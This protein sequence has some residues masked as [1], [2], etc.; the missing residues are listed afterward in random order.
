[1]GRKKTTTA[2][3][4]PAE[5][6]CGFCGRSQ[7]EAGMLVEGKLPGHYICNSCTKL[8]L[9]ILEREMSRRTKHSGLLL[10]IP[11]PREITDKLD[12]YVIGQSQAKKVLAVSVHNHYKRLSSLKGE[13][14]TVVE[15]SNVL[16]LGS[17]GSGKT[18]LAKTLAKIINVPF[19]IG[20]ATTLTEAGYVGDD[21]ESLLLKL[22]HSANMDVGLAEMGIIYID[23]IDK[24]A[25]SS[26]NV[27]ITR[28]VSG[29]G[30]QQALLKMIEGTI[31]SVPPQG[32]RKHPEQK[33]IDIDT[34][35]ILFICGGT[36]VGLNKLVSRRIGKNQMGF[37]TERFKE[38]ASPL[39][40]LSSE[41]F[42]E[43]GLIPELIGRLPL[44]ASLDTLDEASLLRV[45]TEPK[46]ALIKQYKK[47]FKMEDSEVEFSEAALKEIV[48][49]AIKQGTGARGL[50][51]VVDKVMLDIMFDLPELGS[52]KSYVIT[53][54]VVRGE[55][56][57]FAAA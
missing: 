14:D 47:L 33:C 6:I 19:A 52:G 34:S 41:D 13:D 8:S 42:V 44:H 7:R 36:F 18:L 12:K 40:F 54:A 21:V 5:P 24:I 17:T 43:F 28:D 23:E 53:D 48:A 57:L 1:M 29:E 32:G 26:G 55:Q 37:L 20:D 11:T 45:L 31:S 22:L 9:D 25:R 3:P 56:K 27:S 16:L 35:N 30:V 49:S 4:P 2:L 46:N 38:E 10:E 15:K 39:Q 51:G 50:R